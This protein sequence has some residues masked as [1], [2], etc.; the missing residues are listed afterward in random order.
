[1]AME[2]QSH[3]VQVVGLCILEKGCATNSSEDKER[4]V[5]QRV[6]VR[7]KE[8]QRHNLLLLRILE[9]IITFHLFSPTKL[10]G[11]EDEE[12]MEAILGNGMMEHHG[13][14]KTGDPKNPTTSEERGLHHHQLGQ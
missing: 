5:L 7:S 14:I 10:F 3:I 9:E 6:C 8:V 11:L 13:L 12:F 2:E 1:M 4:I